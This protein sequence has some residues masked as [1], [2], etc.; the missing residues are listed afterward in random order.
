MWEDPVPQRRQETERHQRCVHRHH[1]QDWR[2]R[3]QVQGHIR[4][5]HPG[6]TG[7]PARPRPRSDWHQVWRGE[8]GFTLGHTLFI[9]RKVIFRAI[10]LCDSIAVVHGVYNILLSIRSLNVSHKCT[11]FVFIYQHINLPWKLSSRWGL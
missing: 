8:G 10:Q 2:H 11:T 6:R 7:R 4:L 5:Q 9:I 3:G 1:H